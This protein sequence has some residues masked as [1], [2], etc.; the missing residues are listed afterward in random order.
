MHDLILYI[1]ETRI[2]QKPLFR[3]LSPQ[4]ILKYNVGGS[5]YV[6]CCV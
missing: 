6:V 4:L 3:K 2:N 5:K 1:E